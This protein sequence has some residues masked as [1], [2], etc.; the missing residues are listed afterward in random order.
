MFEA[1][2]AYREGAI[3]RSQKLK[4][5]LSPEPP[6]NLVKA[7][8][9]SAQYNAMKA[10][11]QAYYDNDYD[12]AFEIFSPF[13]KT[14]G[15]EKIEGLEEEYKLVAALNETLAIEANELE[16]LENPPKFAR[17][18]GIWEVTRAKNMLDVRRGDRFDF[19]KHQVE[20]FQKSKGFDEAYETESYQV[21]DK[22]IYLT[23]S[24]LT[25]KYSFTKK[26]KLLLRHRDFQT[27]IQLKPYVEDEEI[28]N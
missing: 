28:L 24:D 12:A 7:E 9:L 11:T 20:H 15:A 2:L 4:A 10:A 3:L 22:Q 25:F 18:R 5:E 16:G 8:A 27:E 23:S 14:F 21:N 19:S 26:G 17:L 13:A 6:L 1:K